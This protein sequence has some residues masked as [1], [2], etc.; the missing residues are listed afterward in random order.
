MHVAV[1]AAAWTRSATSPP[2]PD[3]TELLL[4]KVIIICILCL[5]LWVGARRR[6]PV[7]LIFLFFAGGGRVRVPNELVWPARRSG[8]DQ[9]VGGSGTYAQDGG[10]WA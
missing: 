10:F 7:N 3:P 9:G 4:L 6:E 2:T 5:Y 1:C 8:V